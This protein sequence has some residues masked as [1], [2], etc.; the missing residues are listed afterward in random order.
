MGAPD[1]FLHHPSIIHQTH[2]QVQV[3]S[4][5]GPVTA[6]ATRWTAI[7]ADWPRRAL[8]L[9]RWLVALGLMAGAFV[10]GKILL[11]MEPELLPVRLV[12]VEGE[13]HRLSSQ[14]LQRTVTEHLEGGLLTQDIK[15]LQRSV[16]ELPW[17]R[18]ATLRRVW[19][20]RIVLNVEEYRPIARW[21]SDGL[22][23]AEG[24]VFRPKGETFP[25]TLARLSGDDS[26]SPVIAANYLKWRDRLAGIGLTLTALDRDARGAWTLHLGQ[27]L[28]LELGATRVEERLERFMR[29]WRQLAA[30]GRP[31]VVDLRYANGLAVR[32]AQGFAPGDAEVAEVETVERRP[33][34]QSRS[35]SRNRG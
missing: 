1:I 20:D 22:V 19:P 6:G 27:A 7:P 8:A 35:K 3:A 5:A 15:R 17:V 14:Q 10:G 33:Q 26:Q 11:D 24:E 4:A 30:A 25:S 13:V 16:D 18:T 12:T 9:G 29:T 32:W 2:H 31:A 28:D 21:G 23:T 34:A